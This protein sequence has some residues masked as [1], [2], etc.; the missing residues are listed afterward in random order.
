MVLECCCCCC[1]FVHPL[2]CHLCSFSVWWCCCCWA[3]A[4][5]AAAPAGVAHMPAL[6]VVCAHLALHSFSLMYLPPFLPSFFHPRPHLVCPFTHLVHI[7]PSLSH[8]NLVFHDG[9]C[10]SCLCPLSFVLHSPILALLLVHAVPSLLFCA[11][12]HCLCVRLLSSTQVLL[13]MCLCVL[14]F[15]SNSLTCR[16]HL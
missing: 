11:G 9:P 7:I 1:C 6:C 8:T 14:V 4:V 3:A 12:P 15:C 5:I 2:G 10:C 13:S 16:T